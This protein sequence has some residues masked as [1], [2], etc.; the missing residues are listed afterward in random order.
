MSLAGSI[1]VQ[2]I[3]KALVAEAE[4]KRNAAAAGG[5][6]RAGGHAVTIDMSTLFSFGAGGSAGTTYTARSSHPAL[7]TADTTDR[8]LVLTPVAPARVT[9]TV[10]A[11]RVGDSA[12]VAFTVEVEA[13]PSEVPAAPPLAQL[14]LALLLLGGGAYYRVRQAHH[15]AR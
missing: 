11:A 14:L 9:V 6:L 7:V 8:R 3:V 12:E 10:T 15:W 2:A 1:D 4:G 5:R 13:A